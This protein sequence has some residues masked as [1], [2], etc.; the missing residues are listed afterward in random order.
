[1]GRRTCVVV[2]AIST[3]WV[4]GSAQDIPALS[5]SP[6]KATLLVGETRMFRAVGKDGRIRHGI[7]WSVSPED[8]AKLTINGDEA[9]VQ[10]EEASSA[11]LTAYAEG[12]SAEAAIDIRSG[13][14]PTGTMLWS[15]DHMLGCKAKQ[16][17]QAVPSA[18]GPDLYVEEECPQGAFVRALTSDGREMWR[19]QITG[20]GA[21]LTVHPVPKAEADPPAHPLDLHP[22]SVCDGISP[23]MTK[24]E[25]AKR[26]NDRK[27]QLGQKE[28]QSDNWSLEEH[29]SRCTISFDGKTGIV[30][31][32]KKTIVTD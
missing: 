10:A 27:L 30:V 18:N 7:R 24:N 23:G 22:N 9:A 13:A 16:M 17:T 3:L 19:K 28:L 11:V 32:K 31:K 2:L 25:V 6:G 1:M 12:D 21:A 29:G 26:V 8:A 4:W 15:V 20:P 5:V 14:L